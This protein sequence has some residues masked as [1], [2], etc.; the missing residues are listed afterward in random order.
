MV[1]LFYLFG[2]IISI[3]Q[4]GLFFKWNKRFN[5]LKYQYKYKKITGK[6][7]KDIGKSQLYI[8]YFGITILLS[9]I[10]YLIGLLS[11][12]WILFLSIFLVTLIISLFFKLMKRVSDKFIY[13]TSHKFLSFVM[14]GYS[15]T[16]TLLIV[17][18]HFHG[19]DFVNFIKN[20]I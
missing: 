7:H 10:Y 5:E 3:I 9:T 2:F 17:L 20:L 18:N 16:M 4:F 1:T 14:I 6:S 11:S 19:I 8:I 13:S 12:N 15:S